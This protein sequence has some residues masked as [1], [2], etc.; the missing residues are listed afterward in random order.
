MS[1]L[2]MHN[3]EKKG[4]LIKNRITSWKILQNIYWHLAFDLAQRC[5]IEAKQINSKSLLVQA[6]QL[7][8]RSKARLSYQSTTQK[9]VAQH[10]PRT[11]ASG[12]WTHQGI[13]HLQPRMGFPERWNGC[14][15]INRREIYC[16][17]KKKTE[18]L[19]SLGKPILPNNKKESKGKDAHML[20]QP[21]NNHFLRMCKQPLLCLC[22]VFNR[23]VIGL[24]RVQA[25]PVLWCVHDSKVNEPNATVQLGCDVK[26]LGLSLRNDPAQFDNSCETFRGFQKRKEKKKNDI[27]GVL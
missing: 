25:I 18:N 11:L 1:T 17:S 27:V 12:S 20:G 4:G 6:W 16:E 13:G 23:F 21:E 19:L 7:K 22:H 5:R 24:E 14:K 9:I 10:L 2:Q 26:G 3:R 8:S 15:Q